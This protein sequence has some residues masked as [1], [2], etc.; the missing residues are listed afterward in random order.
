MKCIIF[1][2]ADRLG[3]D[4][5]IAELTSGLR[6]YTI[7]HW[8]FPQ[9]QDNNEKTEWQK[10]TFLEE[11]THYAKSYLELRN[12]TFFWNRSHIG[13]FVYG[14]IYRDSAPET[15][16]P[17]LEE[18]FAFDINLDVYLIHLTADPEFLVKQDD[19]QS[20]SNQLEKKREEIAAF[21]AAVNSSKIINKL[22]IKVNNNDQYND[23]QELS[24]QIRSFVGL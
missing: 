13:E 21:E 23:F 19:G 4:S 22:T 5:H 7:R 12:H 16:V 3:K 6:N 11:F 17:D 20:Y 10:K 2:G 24:Q 9:G 15:W 8:A 18:S 1:E 14:T